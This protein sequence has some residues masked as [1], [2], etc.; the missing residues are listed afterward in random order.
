MYRQSQPTL[1]TSQ[2]LV[3]LPEVDLDQHIDTYPPS[4]IAWQTIIWQVQETGL[5]GP[6]RFQIMVS[7][8]RVNWSLVAGPVANPTEGEEV[9]GDINPG[10]LQQFVLTDAHL[11]AYRYFKVQVASPDPNPNKHGV[12]LVT[13]FAR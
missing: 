10:G 1:V 13:V 11:M 6:L 5:D 2:A 9:I 3:D 8:D 4:K 12:A 7:M